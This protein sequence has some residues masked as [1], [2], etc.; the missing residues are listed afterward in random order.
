MD[1]KEKQFIK[2]TETPVNKL[3]ITLAVPATVGMLITTIYNMA[4]TYFVSK[5][6]TSASGAVGIVFSLMAILQAFA[7]MYGQGAGCIIAAKLGAG[8]TESAS[9]TATLALFSAI[10]TGLFILVFGNIFINPFMKLLGSTDTILPYARTYARC[11][12]CAAPF[13][14]SSNV[15]NNILRYEGM[16]RDS[17]TGMLAGGILNIILDPCLIFIAGLGVLGAGFATAVSQLVSFSLLL[18]VFLK[19]RT[20]SKLGVTHYKWDFKLFSTICATGLPS[21]IRQGMQSISGMVLNTYAGLMGGDAAIA[22]MSIVGR[23]TFF[24]FAVGLGV[25][26][27]YQPVAGFNYGA[28]KYKR[29]KDASLFTWMIAQVCIS[30]M[31]IIGLIFAERL[32]TFFRNDPDVIIIGAKALR[33]QLIALLTIP[34]HVT[35]NMSLQS[36]GHHKGASV[37]SFLK[38]GLFFIP[39]IFILSNTI[40]L[41]GVQIAQPIAD[42][43][44]TIASIPFYIWFIRK[45]DRLEANKN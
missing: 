3:V 19:G 25:G 38:S 17:M 18:S 23:V 40:G 9:Q 8:E 44:T 41:L 12:L 16:A 39:I 35:S 42:V 30:V 37:L 34:L 26:Q 29:V 14:M 7:F 11:I 6:G 28:K 33:Y 4:D 10:A 2:M 27:G 22:A 13:M 15:L 24:C 5:L 20:Q 36:T 1:S 45:L 21:L 32:V 31:A 43:F